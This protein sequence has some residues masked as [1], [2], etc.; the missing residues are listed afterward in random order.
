M[1]CINKGLKR[2]VSLFSTVLVLGM[3]LNGCSGNTEIENTFTAD[4]PGFGIQGES[5]D[6]DISYF[7]ED[8]CVADE[9][10]RAIEAETSDALAACFFNLDTREILY[11]ENIH[12]KLYPASTTK[13]MTALV[14]LEQGDLDAQ[15]TVS[16][17][18]ITFHESGVS[19]AKLK[20]GDVLT[21]RQ[22]LYGLLVVS[23]NDAANV[24]AEMTAGSIDQFV[25]L[26]NE[27]AAQIGATNTHFVNPNGLHDE[28][29]Y[30]TAYDLYLMFQEAMKYDLFL[31]ILE[32]PSYDVTYL[33]A[34]GTEVTASWTS[35][36]LFTKGDVTVPDGVSAAGGKTGTTSAA[37][38]CLVQLF[39]DAQGQRYV[40][41]ILG[42]SDRSVMYQEMQSFLSDL[43]N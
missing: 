9:D 21:L 36:N 20:E 8:L 39:E 34:G 15:T 37:K 25:A 19:T 17:E 41:I 11:A 40:A 26:M 23:A 16:Q 3:F 7:A 28:E 18:A 13:I 42:C 38:C 43:N 4:R 27:K 35:S 31:E 29:H 12:D 24:I 1:R 10:V 22:L 5:G 30:T 6:T 32:A 2:A 33:S 14:A